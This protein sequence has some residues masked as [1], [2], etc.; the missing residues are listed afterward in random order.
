MEGSGDQSSGSAFATALNSQWL[1]T[2]TLVPVPASKAKSDPLFDDRVMR[3]L[4]A[5]RPNDPL[6][7]RELVVQRQRSRHG[8]I[9]GFL[10]RLGITQ[11]TEA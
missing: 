8:V 11:G 5:I 6:D 1:D 2:A 7:I 9:A 10:L 4:H 3:M